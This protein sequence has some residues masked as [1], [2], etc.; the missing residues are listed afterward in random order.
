MTDE[1]PVVAGSV[2]DHDETAGVGLWRVLLEAVRDGEDDHLQRDGMLAAE[3]GD[4]GFGEIRDLL[5]ELIPVADLLAETPRDADGFPGFDHVLHLDARNPLELLPRPVAGQVEEHTD[6][7]LREGHIVPGGLNAKGLELS[8][9]P[10]S[11]APDI[12]GREV[13]E[14]LL[15]V[16]GPVHVAAALE[17][18]VALAELRGDLRQGLCRCDAHGYRYG[19]LPPAFPG[20]LLGVGVVVHV[21]AVQVQERLVYGIDLDARGVGA[22]DLLDPPRHVA[23]QREIPGEDGHVILLHDVPDLEQRVAHLDAECL[24]FVAPRHRAAVVVAEHDD[25]LPVQLRT[26]DPLARCEEIVAVG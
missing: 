17:L 13:P 14:D 11:D 12:L 9:H 23:I 10:P 8:H 1:G 25:R 21:D 16:L 22:K 4:S 20:D 6:R 18:G 2:G 7:R 15:D 5:A 24:G 19:G 26:E 3:L